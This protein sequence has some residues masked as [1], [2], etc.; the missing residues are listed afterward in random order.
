MLQL[1]ITQSSIALANNKYRI[2]EALRIHDTFFSATRF[3]D[4]KNKKTQ[5]TRYEDAA[6]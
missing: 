6:A 2:C 1:I 3:T 4:S 5:S